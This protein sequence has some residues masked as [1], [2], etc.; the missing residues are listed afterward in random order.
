MKHTLFIIGV[1]L[2]VVVFSQISRA[3]GPEKAHM[4]LLEERDELD[5]EIVRVLEEEMN[6][7]QDKLDEMEYEYIALTD[8][9]IDMQEELQEECLFWNSP[10]RTFYEELG[11]REV[12]L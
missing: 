11:C 5:S 2:L 12:K 8:E 1:L 6:P 9:L 7:I 4:R 10:T 3:S